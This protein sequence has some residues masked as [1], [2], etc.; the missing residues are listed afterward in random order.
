MVAVVAKGLRDWTLA[1]GSLCLVS[2]SR[3]REDEVRSRLRR[4]SDEFG[5]AQY[6]ANYGG[7]NLYCWISARNGEVTR[8]FVYAGEELVNEGSRTQA[9]EALNWADLETPLDID[10]EDFDDEEW[11]KGEP[12]PTEVSVAVVARGWSVDPSTVWLPTSELVLVATLGVDVVR[13]D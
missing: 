2:P 9:E 7:T 12:F 6:F 10:A 5:E 1:G 3:D 13:G 4:L 11:D 8:A